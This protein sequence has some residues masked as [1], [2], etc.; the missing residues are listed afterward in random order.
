MA[1]ENALLLKLHCDAD[2]TVRENLKLAHLMSNFKKLL[3]TF[4][5]VKEGTCYGVY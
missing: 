5:A 1:G 4:A 3:D 2:N